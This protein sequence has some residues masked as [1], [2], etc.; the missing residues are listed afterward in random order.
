VVTFTA[1]TQHGDH[2]YQLQ[3][4]EELYRAIHENSYLTIS[5]G[6]PTYWP[7]VANKIPD[8]LDFFETSGI[9]ENYI[10]VTGRHDLSSDH[11]P[12]IATISTSI[13]LRQPQP[14]L[15][16]S[17]INSEHFRTI[18]ESTIQLTSKLKHHMT[19]KLNTT[20]TSSYYKKL[21][22]GQLPYLLSA[23]PQ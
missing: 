17:K 9:S 19:L 4:A 15:H 11:T 5:P 22:K 2:D 20:N 23:L 21:P 3:K 10:S 8:L 12:I 1:S 13:P 18:L 16:N 14:R 7:T 6:T